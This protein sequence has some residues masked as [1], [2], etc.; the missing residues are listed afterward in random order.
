MQWVGVPKTGRLLGVGAK[1]QGNKGGGSYRVGRCRV[2]G[3]DGWFYVG[4]FPEGLVTQ[5]S[6]CL[7]Q[8]P[9]DRTSRSQKHI[10]LLTS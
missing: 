6:C 2:A 5:A 10:L 1:T 7:Q 8:S 4:L 3:A 9:G